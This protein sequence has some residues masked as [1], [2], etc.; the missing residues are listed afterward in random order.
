MHEYI[1]NENESVIVLRSTP[2]VAKSMQE[3]KLF[4]HPT[5]P[6]P[7]DKNF[8]ITIDKRI[9]FENYTSSA[10]LIYASGAF[11][12][13]EN[14]NTPLTAGRYCSIASELRLM[15]E[16][17]PIE[18]VTSSAFTYCYLP[19]YYK[20]QFVAGHADLLEGKQ[21]PD[22]PPK[23][24][25]DLPKIEHDVWIGQQVILARGITIHT[26]AVV[27]AGSVVTKDVPPYTVVGGNPARPIKKRFPD[28]IAERLLR[29]TWWEYHPRYLYEF[30]YK[31]P[32]EFCRLF[33]HA[34]EKMALDRIPSRTL[35]WRDIIETANAF[36]Q[37]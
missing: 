9:I 19:H 5:G 34:Q 28:E 32:E 15:G 36:A 3:L 25:A 14:P 10:G 29:T 13:S 30:G 18:Y 22:V 4:R 27:A 23:M 6:F 35:T 7:E 37:N 16:R 26:G 1:F 8:L 31:N 17:H 33:E 2:P 21:Q 20:A 24:F 11:T 12:Y